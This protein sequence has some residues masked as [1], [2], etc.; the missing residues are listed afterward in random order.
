MFMNRRDK[1]FLKRIAR[2]RA[3]LLIKYAFETYRDDPALARRYTR[4]AKRLCERY[5]VRL[6]G[7]RRLFCQRCFTPW[8]PDETV[9]IEPNPYN[10]NLLIYRCKICGYKRSFPKPFA[11]RAGGPER[12]DKTDG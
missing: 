9:D 4:L 2:E 5:N 8:I 12:S 10:E 6:R 11:E 7:L 1:L 3:E